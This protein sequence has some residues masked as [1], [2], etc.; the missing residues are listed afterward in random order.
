VSTDQTRRPIEQAADTE[1]FTAA[2]VEHAAAMLG[3][4]RTILPVDEAEQVVQETFIQYWID[5]GR[6]DPNRGSLRTYLKVV[7]RYRAID[8]L[9]SSSAA[10]RRD[11]DWE[12]SMPRVHLDAEFDEAREGVRD[13][14]AALP[15]EQRDPIVIAFFTGATYNEVAAQLGLAEGTVKSRIRAGLAHLRDDLAGLRN[16][17][18]EEA[19]TGLQAALDRRDT[20]K[21]AEGILIEGGATAAEAPPLLRSIARRARRSIDETAAD[22]VADRTR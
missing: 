7:C 2:Y 14:L 13:A 16:R 6:H 4:I 22:V 18:H 5:P 8:W 20:T 11:V 1:R 17:H 21:Q 10:E 15:A 19:L 12:R 3:H 9:R